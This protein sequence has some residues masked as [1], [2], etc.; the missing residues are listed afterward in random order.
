MSNKDD[1][2]ASLV[3]AH[4]A[5]LSRAGGASLATRGLRELSQQD[6][7]WRQ[8]YVS[9]EDWMVLIPSPL[10]FLRGVWS[11]ATAKAVLKALLR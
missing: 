2:E 7:R 9:L 4:P 1:N 10:P 6:I 8:A 5:A 3:P 11:L